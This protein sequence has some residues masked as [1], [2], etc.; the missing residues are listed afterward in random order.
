M[1]LQPYRVAIT[2]FCR[3]Q[4][5]ASCFA[6]VALLAIVP[7]SHAA[8][9]WDGDGND[10]LWFNPANWNRN[11]N[12][13]IT[14]P[15]G[16]GAVT[17][18]EISIGTAALNGGQGVIYDTSPGPFFPPADALNDPPPDFTYQKIAQLYISRAGA[19]QTFVTPDN[20]VTIKGDLEL[21]A[22]MVVGRSSGVATVATNGKVVQES[23][24]VKVNLNVIDLGNAEGGTRA[25]FGNGTYDYKSGILEVSIDGGSGLRLAAGGSGGVGGV[26]RF[27]MR[28]PGPTSPGYVRAYDVNVAANDGNTTILANGT[29]NGVGIFEFHSNGA[30]GTRPVQVNQN[31][32]INNGASGDIGSVRSSRLELVLDAAPTVDISGIPQDLGLFDVAFTEVGGTSTTRRRRSGRLLFERRRQHAVRSGRHGIRDVR[33]VNLQLDDQLHGQYHLG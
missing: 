27:I 25:G 20:T 28:N 30:N 11:D 2:R 10:G 24:T 18:T 31:L 1:R 33:R 3:E 29:T 21:T 5:F 8:I 22:N 7:A 23:G 12:D 9:P 26:G 15:P 6:L 32:I 19:G 14:L 17:D 4:A 13:N 16:T